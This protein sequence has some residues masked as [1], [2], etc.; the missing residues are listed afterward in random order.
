M[1]LLP[2]PNSLQGECPRSDPKI[3]KQTDKFCTFQCYTC[4]LVYVETFPNY[5]DSAK[6]ENYRKKLA[7]IERQQKAADSRPKIFI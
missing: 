4:K 7:Q 1:S 2:C 5:D 6:Y 3:I